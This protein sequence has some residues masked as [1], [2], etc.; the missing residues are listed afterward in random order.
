LLIGAGSGLGAGLAILAFTLI[1]AGVGAAGTSLLA[2]LASGVAP[3]RRAA[4]A[5][6][7]WIM[8]VAGIVIS[9]G[10]AGSLLDPFSEQRLALVA[11]GVALAA[12]SL[13][14]V[15]MAGLERGIAVAVRAEPVADFREALREMAADPEARRFTCFVFV[16]MLA[17]SMQDLILE[18]FAGLVFAMSPGESTKLAGVQHGGVLLGMILAG[19][20]GSAFAGRRPVELRRWTLVGCLGSALALAGLAAAAVAGPGWPLTA[21]VFALGLANGLFAVAAIGSM[22]GLAGAGARS[23]EGVRMGVWGAAQAMAFGLGG[24]IGAVGV[25]AARALLS[26]TGPAFQLIFAT[27]AALFVAAAWLAVRASQPIARQRMATA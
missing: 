21:N 19:V 16:S 4:A 11:G 6:T 24:L 23:R 25:D 1:G 15:A 13:A 22:M 14:L 10:V 27:E 9:A 17:Y 26:G 3:Q 2:L 8:M 12:F 5:A 20:G 18:P 7:T